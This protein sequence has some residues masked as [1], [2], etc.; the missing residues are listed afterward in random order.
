[1]K[2]CKK[3]F[4][5]YI[6]V[7]ILLISLGESL[8]AQTVTAKNLYSASG[9]A[10][11]EDEAREDAVGSLATM[12][13]MRVDQQSVG[14]QEMREKNGKLKKNEKVLQKSVTVTTDVPLLGVTYKSTK[15]KDGKYVEVEAALNPATSR[16]LYEAELK[17]TAQKLEAL[18][19]S[20]N[21]VQARQSAITLYDEY[22]RLSEVAL[23]LKT[24]N[25]PVLSM[26]RTSFDKTVF[27]YAGTVSTLQSAS[28][29][30]TTGIKQKKIYVYPA[31]FGNVQGTS[32]FA[33]ALQQYV[34]SSLGV[35]AV[36]EQKN[37]SY[38]LSG[39]YLEG[40]KESNGKCRLDVSYRLVSRGGRVVAASPIVSVL[41]EGYEGKAYVPCGY[42]FE[43]ELASAVSSE[44]TFFADIRINGRKD[45]LIFGQGEKLYIDVKASEPCL[46]YI[47]GYVFN[48]DSNAV[49]F[50]YLY[51][52]DQIQSGKESFIKH[53]GSGYE[54]T[55]V[56]INPSVNGVPQ[57]IEIIPPFGTEMLQV[58]AVKGESM[59]DFIHRIPDYRESS[60]YYVVGDNPSGAIRYTRGLN[61]KKNSEAK[62]SEVQSCEAHVSFMSHR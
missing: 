2:H 26:D 6:V 20:L 9:T 7:T 44:D 18:F 45:G 31:S 25:I 52:F 61:I 10:S 4:F 24:Q 29:L 54:N 16:P 57:A 34:M 51:P 46:M 56:N 11:T 12:M 60:D 15:S 58:F 28:Q 33:Y 36:S 8:F 41:P 59:E 32:E 55:W 35:L 19:S 38:Y 1:M 47:V 17:K 3:Q 53:I 40:T 42:E 21:D 43:K 13:Y 62:S 30:I 5:F 37:A 22:E 14:A 39:T 48:K 50:A 49:P 27:K 23:V